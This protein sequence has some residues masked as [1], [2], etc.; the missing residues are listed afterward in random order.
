MFGFICAI[1]SGIAMSLQG[2]FNTRLGEKIGT[3][4]TNAFV[5]G[6]ALVLTLILVLFWGDGDFKSIR[7]VNKLYLT[8][9]I[10]SVIIIYTVM[11]SI[12]TLGTTI[13]IGT[14]LV[15]QLAAAA[16]INAF[17]LFGS[18]KITFGWH[19]IVGL[20]L[21]TAGIVVLKWKF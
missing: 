4:E 1:I 3:F 9:G 17:G 2:V 16:V 18:E 19:E 14:I 20:V 7:T 5:Q 8:S 11:K 12:G 13:G 10:L 15:A 21:M 6:S